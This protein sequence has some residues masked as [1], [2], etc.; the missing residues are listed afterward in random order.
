M[1]FFLR[2]ITLKDLGAPSPSHSNGCWIV[3]TICTEENIDSCTIVAEIQNFEAVDKAQVRKGLITLLNKA[4]T[5]LPLERLYKDKACHEVHNF[6]YRHRDF[7]IWRIRMGDAPRM[8]FIYGSEKEL[9][10]LHV[11]TKRV[12]KLNK[13]KKDQLAQIA[14]GYLEA[15]DDH[16]TQRITREE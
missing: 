8:Y 1:P 4:D 5:G 14:K 9:L 11:A 7:T 2:R 16:S 3:S 10:L 6:S 15:V 12:D 13:G